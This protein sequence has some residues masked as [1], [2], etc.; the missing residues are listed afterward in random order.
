[1]NNI[2]NSEIVSQDVGI[3]FTYFWNNIIFPIIERIK[4]EVDDEFK[5]ISDFDYAYK[6]LNQYCNDL[7]NFYKEKREWLKTV[8]LPHS[9]CA[10]LDIHKLGAVLCRSLIAYKPFYIDYKRAEKYVF[11]KFCKSKENN[12][13][14]YLNNVY[15]NYKV[16]FYCSVGLVY[17]ELLY[18]YKESSQFEKVDILKKNGRLFFYKESSNHDNFE[19]SCILALQKN[20]VLCRDFDYLAYAEML[21]QLEKHNE[22][23]LNNS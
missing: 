3:S 1:M 17:I 10:L 15:A 23:I 8:Y 19:K 18:R 2:V 21:F 20:D 9:S 4:S 5:L 22:N 14:W 16:A 11:N 6:D 7:F 12:L 13:D